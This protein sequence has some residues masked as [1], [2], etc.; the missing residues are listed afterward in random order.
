ML[1]HFAYMSLREVQVLSLETRQRRM[2][3]KSNGAP[4][5]LATVWAG[6]GRLGLDWTPCPGR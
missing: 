2:M 4:K 1:P 6:G 5:F 3:M